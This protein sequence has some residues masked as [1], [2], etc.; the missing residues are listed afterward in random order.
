M[1]YYIGWFICRVLKLG[2]MVS[3]CGYSLVNED[4]LFEVRIPAWLADCYD[5]YWF[6]LLHKC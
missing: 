5:V 6:R 1:R 3:E 2:L 4:T